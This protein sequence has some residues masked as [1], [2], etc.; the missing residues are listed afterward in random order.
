VSK[1]VLLLL[2]SGRLSVYESEF[3]NDDKLRKT[4]DRAH[5]DGDHDE[6]GGYD[7]NSHILPSKL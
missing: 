6:G 5:D 3:E 2:Q 1:A 7:S 4:S